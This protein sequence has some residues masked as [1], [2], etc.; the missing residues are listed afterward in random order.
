MSEMSIQVHCSSSVC[1]QET[2]SIS[3]EFV[4]YSFFSVGRHNEPNGGTYFI[5]VSDVLVSC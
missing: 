1:S 2:F 3:S 5:G 4:Y